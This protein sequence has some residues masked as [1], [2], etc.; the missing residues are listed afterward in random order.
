MQW[1]LHG[2]EKDEIMPF[3]ATGVNLEIITLSEISQ[4]E[5][6]S[7]I[8]RKDNCYNNRKCRSYP[9][10]LTLVAEVGLEP[11]AV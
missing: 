10:E 5:K 3:A 9:V 1:I 2:H 4:K 11:R 6:D 8:C 7:L